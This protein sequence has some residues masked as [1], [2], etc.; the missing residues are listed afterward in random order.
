VSFKWEE[1]RGRVGEVGMADR[2]VGV[3]GSF[4]GLDTGEFLAMNPRGRVP[5][6]DDSGVVVWESHAIL[7]YLAAKYASGTS[8]W[9]VDPAERAKA[10]QWMDWSQTAL[11]IAFLIGI[12]WGW[13]RTPEAKRNMGAVKAGIERNK[14]YLRLFIHQLA[15]KFIMLRERLSF[16]DVPFVEQLYT[17]LI[18]HFAAM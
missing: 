12:F 2:Q 15:D 18:F 16:C 13:Y 17:L 14:G 8:F 4:G 1:V 10:D 6:I 3:G 11:Q 5:V 7:R 9:N